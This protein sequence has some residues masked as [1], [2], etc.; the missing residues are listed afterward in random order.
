MNST[1]TT[2]EDP[3]RK[4]RKTRLYLQD[5]VEG[6]YRKHTDLQ[7]FEAA[8]GSH[9]RDDDAQKELQRIRDELLE[10]A[11]QLKELQ[12]S[13]T[14]LSEKELDKLL[15][16]GED[17]IRELKQHLKE[18]GVLDPSDQ[19][20]ASR[21]YCEGGVT[22]DDV[23]EDERRKLE[24]DLDSDDVALLREVFDAVVYKN[25]TLSQAL[26]ISL[27]ALKQAPLVA[28]VVGGVENLIGKDGPVGDVIV[29]AAGVVGS[30]QLMAVNAEKGPSIGPIPMVGSFALSI[31][32]GLVSSWR[33]VG[34]VLRRRPP[35]RK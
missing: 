31:A 34:P 27:A 8:I 21:E 5:Q 20:M 11:K 29:N 7:L 3:K 10:T 19:F 30:T 12:Q 13:G 1:E 9:V 35:S 6:E 26:D 22:W 15:Q 2:G 28:R 16:D 4:S 32:W 18:I 25:I 33:L 23:P 14:Q 24:Q 17:R